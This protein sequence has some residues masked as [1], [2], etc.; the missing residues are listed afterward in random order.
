M[1]TEMYNNTI[2]ADVAIHTMEITIIISHLCKIHEVLYISLLCACKQQKSNFLVFISMTF[3]KNKQYLKTSKVLKSSSKCTY[4]NS[5]WQIKMLGIACIMS[6]LH[7]STVLPMVHVMISTSLCKETTRT[8]KSK[9]KTEIVRSPSLCCR[10]RFLAD[11]DVHPSL[12]CYVDDGGPCSRSPQSLEA[13]RRQIWRL[14]L[15]YR[16]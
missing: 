16:S 7:C 5:S 6:S 9:Y 11:T 3:W 2:A 10:T 8:S 12:N 1:C 14:C 15:P 4:L 13:I